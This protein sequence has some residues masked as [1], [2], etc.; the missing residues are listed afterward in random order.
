VFSPSVFVFRPGGIALT[1]PEVTL[2]NAAQRLG[3]SYQ[4]TLNAVLRGELRGRQDDRGRWRVDAKD[5]ERFKSE[6]KAHAQN[7]K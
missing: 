1:E 2:V 6:R 3:L 5:I 7:Q 4:K